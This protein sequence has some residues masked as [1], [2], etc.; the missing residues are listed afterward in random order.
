[1]VKGVETIIGMKRDVVFG[2]VIVFG[3][4]GIFVEILKDA[5]L[6]IAPVSKDEALA[7]IREIKGLPLLTGARGR[8][9]VNLDAL[10]AA[11]ASLSQLALDYP[12]VQEIDFNPVFATP[13]GAYIVDA[14]V[15]K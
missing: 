10:A 13:K 12:E 5:A 15:M 8:E 9:P 11:I 14:R 1:M 6:R 4:G 3:L 2:P 7:Q